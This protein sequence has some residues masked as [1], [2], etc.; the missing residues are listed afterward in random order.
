MQ[1][2]LVENK[3]SFALIIALA[4]LLITALGDIFITRFQN[5]GLEAE[6]EGSAWFEEWLG[7]S[8]EARI[9]QGTDTENRI[10]VFP[11]KGIIGTDNVMGLPENSIVNQLDSI[12]DDPTIRGILLDVDSP[13]GTVYESARIWEK[14]KEVQELTN[15]PIYTSMGGVAASG[16]YYVAAPSDKIYA[17]EETVT[18]S[19]GVIAD[20][21]NIAELEE[22][23]GIKHEVIKSGEYKDIG[24]AS[25]KM[26]DEEREIN[27]IQV[28][29]FFEKFIKVIADGRQMSEGEVYQLAD[30]RVYTGK[31][32]LENGL[33]DEIGYFEDAL[34]DM[35]NDLE[36]DDPIV[37]QQTDA[38]S[39]W[40]QL[41]GP[42]GHSK[43]ASVNKESNV[44]SFETEA[45]SY[46]EKNR[47]KG[48]LPEFYY[49]Y[50]GM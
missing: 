16:G 19:I 26:T 25:R 20:Y 13:G 27:Q 29:E 43:N 33:V 37:F 36:L 47:S 12:M 42:V 1:R 28:D 40:G 31:Q 48:N 30:G 24:S 46:I 22:K 49:L 9:L 15:L 6:L 34:E 44:T 39:F 10:V 38:L 21:V 17:A 18:G 4:I 35:I 32:A 7:G 41:L 2:K 5:R 23:I 50:G 45:F 14:I 3:R 11:I 8:P